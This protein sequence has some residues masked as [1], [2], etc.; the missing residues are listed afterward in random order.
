MSKTKLQGGGSNTGELP[1]IE[2]DL[3]VH[4]DETAAKI[5]ELHSILSIYLASFNSFR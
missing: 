5:G 3:Q 2:F 1:S 4:R